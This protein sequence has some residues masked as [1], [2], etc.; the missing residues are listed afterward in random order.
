MWLG[1]LNLVIDTREI[2]KVRNLPDVFPEDLLGQLVDREV[3][4]AI[5]L[6]PEIQPIPIALYKMGQAGMDELKK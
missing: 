4:F 5:D 1:K 2:L 3:Q 6:H